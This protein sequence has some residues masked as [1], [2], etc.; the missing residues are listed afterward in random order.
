M[1][2]CVYHLMRNVAPILIPL[3]RL[4]RVAEEL[5]FHLL[6]FPTAEGVIARVDLVAERLADLGDPKRKFKT[7]AVEDVLEI[8]EDALGRFG[9]EVGDC[10]LLRMAPT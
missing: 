9:T 7:A 8:G 5:D 1:P 6:E 4:V 3:H 10:D 2:S